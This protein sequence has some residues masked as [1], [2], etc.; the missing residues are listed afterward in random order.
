MISDC[1][2]Q[3]DNLNRNPDLS[4]RRGLW[5]LLSQQKDEKLSEMYVLQLSII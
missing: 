3:V 5:L 4:A 1:T 2:Y